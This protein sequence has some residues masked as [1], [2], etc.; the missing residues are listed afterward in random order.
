MRL[1]TMAAVMSYVS[2]IEQDSASFYETY[3]EK[4][5]ELKDTFLSWAKEN[6]IFEKNIKRT[7]FGVITDTLE[8]NFAFEGLDTDDYEIGAL[9]SESEDSSEATKRAHE[10]E[11]VIKNFYLKAAQL[12]EGLMA[13]I[14]R[15]FRK[16]AK[17]REQRCFSLEAF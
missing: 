12:S 9:L 16:I 17:T 11:G 15:L 3:A 7:Y 13:D 1:N 4:Y 14:P 2:N 5:P 10:I 6:K 8:S